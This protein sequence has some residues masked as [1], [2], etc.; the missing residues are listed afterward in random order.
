MSQLAQLLQH[1]HI[2]LA[3]AALVTRYVFK[4]LHPALTAAVQHGVTTR[5][6][7][8]ILMSAAITVALLLSSSFAVMLVTLLIPGT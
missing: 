8:Q 4:L 3:A 2:A 6:R 1:H 7:K 5:D